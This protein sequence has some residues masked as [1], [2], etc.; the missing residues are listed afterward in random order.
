MDPGSSNFL[1][2]AKRL[3]ALDPPRAAI[4]FANPNTLSPT[5]PSTTRAPAQLAVGIGQTAAGNGGIFPGEL[6]A[7]SANRK[8]IQPSLAD[9]QLTRGLLIKFK[10]AYYVRSTVLRTPGYFVH[11][12]SQPDLTAGGESESSVRPKSGWRVLVRP[13]MEETATF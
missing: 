5:H 11:S 12:K 3:H 7:D 4:R 6:A 13:M 10:V 9:Q 8:K 1:S 2:L